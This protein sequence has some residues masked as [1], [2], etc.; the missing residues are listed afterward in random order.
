MTNPSNTKSSS[1]HRYVH[2][3]TQPAQVVID[4]FRSKESGLSQEEI[5]QRQERYG[6]NTLPE[7]KKD[8]FLKIFFR[9]FQSPLLYILV[10]AS[11]VALAMGEITDGFII[12]AVLVLNGVI[13]AFQEGKAQ[14]ALFALKKLASTESLVLRDGRHI[15]IPSSEIVP[16]DILIIKEGDKIPADARLVS[17]ESLTMSEAILTGESNP[18][19]KKEDV[20]GV[21]ENIIISD[22][23]NMV[24]SG[25]TVTRGHGK[26]LV[27]AIGKDTELGKIS[28]RISH[29]ESEIPL[30][31][32]MRR[33]ARVIIVTTSA[34][35]ALLFVVGLLTGST[36]QEMLL[37]AISLLVSVIP[38]GL[39]VVLTLILA[40]GVKRMSE[41][42]VLV[43]RLQAVEALG[44]AKIIAV[45]KTG[46]LTKNEL[47]VKNLFVHNQ[48]F[49]VD[50]VGYEAP[51]EVTCD[52]RPAGEDPG[53]QLL[54]RL[55]GISA[56]AQILRGEEI[57]ITG[58]P[59]EAALIVFAEKL[60]KRQDDLREASPVIS[61]M[62]FDYKNKYYAM[63]V[64]D[65]E[66]TLGILV[67]APEAVIE[68]C[69]YI[70]QEGDVGAM[71]E[72]AQKT[73]YDQMEEFSRKGLRVI[74]VAQKKE[75]SDQLDDKN[76]SDYEFVGFCALK[77][78]LRSEVGEAMNQAHE[79]GMRVVMITGDHKITA[80]AIAEEAGVFVEGDRVLTGNEISE[81]SDHDLSLQLDKV[82]VFARVTPEHKLRIIEAYKKR[83]DIVAMTGD[84]VNDV[85]PLVSA[86]LGVAMGK[87]GTEVTK[88]AADIV[89]LDDNFGNIPA[90]VEE[91]RNMHM[92]IK[93]TLLY[94]FSTNLAELLVIAVAIL[95]LMP[96]PLSPAQIVWLNLVTDSFLVLALVFIPPE[97]DLLH[98]GAG[99]FSRYVLDKMTAVRLVLFGVVMTVGTLAVFI[100][101]QAVSLS[102]AM[103]MAFLTLSLFQIFRL[104]SVRSRTRSAFTENPFRYPWLMAATLGALGL[105][106]FA[107]YAPFM[108]ELLGTV[109]VTFQDWLIVGG[110]GF[111]ILLID[112]VRKV[113]LR[114][115]A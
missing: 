66:R 13:G 98:G 50:G 108:Q 62:P 45:D 2:W 63:V 89:L 70:A 55:V 39:P 12:V 76:I 8:S 109:A 87:I 107:V 84:G 74:A 6:A 33:L 91:G 92:T 111:S 60:G 56:S 72:A 65:A 9:Q 103:T 81:M 102:Y 5:I 51:G 49:D 28:E 21:Q 36:F 3:C 42:N 80:Q 27:V 106:I 105:Q 18:I 96:L 85:P 59:T 46:T 110:V 34:V 95:A 53:V 10:A 17:T 67:G 38:E 16:G 101:A 104:W 22:Q 40:Q 77:D 19:Q 35:I 47:V 88:E 113:W 99:K 100:L 37:V 58:D 31:A 4:E 1:S 68:K 64:E 75:V 57:K 52:N 14:D 61:E 25:T 78:A 112:E 82:S 20:L 83:G 97:D 115:K 43:K 73:L 11:L 44:Q 24:F 90:A 15:V 86:H 93:K 26:A 79:A 32:S 71:T 7:K 41:R 94:L 114:K 29:I 23:N 69:S 54:A 30:Q 48:I